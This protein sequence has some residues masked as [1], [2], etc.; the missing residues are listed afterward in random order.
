M[1]TSREV[2]FVVYGHLRRNAADVVTPAG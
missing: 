1:I 2:R